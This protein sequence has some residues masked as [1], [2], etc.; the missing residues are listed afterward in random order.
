MIHFWDY[1][2][3]TPYN[4]LHG[5]EFWLGIVGI[6]GIA[7]ILLLLWIIVLCIRRR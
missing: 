7:L 1:V 5:P 6:Q 2:T 3:I 4:L